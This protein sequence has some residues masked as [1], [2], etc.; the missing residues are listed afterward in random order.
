MFRTVSSGGAAHGSPQKGF[1]GLF[2]DSSAPF[3][4]DRV[5]DGTDGGGSGGSA[6]AAVAAALDG[7]AENLAANGAPLGPD[8]LFNGLAA[9]LANHGAGPET[10]ALLEGLATRLLI[11]SEAP[12]ETAPGGFSPSKWPDPAGF[13]ELWPSPHKLPRD[14]ILALTADLAA[15]TADEAAALGIAASPAFLEAGIGDAAGLRERLSGGDSI[16]VRAFRQA[17]AG[18]ASR[19]L[20]HLA[21][22]WE[23]V[24]ACLGDREAMLRLSS[25]MTG[26]AICDLTLSGR[27]RTHLEQMAQAWSRL[28][29]GF[30]KGSADPLA[31]ASQ[32]IAVEG[33]RLDSLDAAAQEMAITIPASEAAPCQERASAPAGQPSLRPLDAIGDAQSAD[34]QNASRRFGRLLSPLPLLGGRSAD[35]V[36]RSLSAEFP[37]FSDANAEIA[38]SAAVCGRA[39]TG[40]FRL[41]RPLLLVGPPGSGKTRWARRAAVACGVA[42]APV[43]LSGSASSIVL[44]GTERGWSSGTPSL[45]ARVM[46]ERR[47]ANPLIFLDEVDKTAESKQNGSATDA[48]LMLTEPETAARYPDAY[49][50]GL[51]D[52]SRISFVMAANSLAILPPALLDR[53]TVVHVGRPEA[54]HFGILLG[55]IMADLQAEAGMPDGAMPDL[56]DARPALERVFLESRSA[57][58]LKAAAEKAFRAAIW[59]PPGPRAVG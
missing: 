20:E 18:H 35:E 46:Q 54:R 57:R 27:F 53:V 44:A 42:F 4:M 10:G 51:L 14:E 49:L 24:L 12:F 28:A 40:Y 32:I 7:I 56:S 59:T 11:A 50:L 8:A 17:A 55:G 48:L 16:A 22:N 45:P 43:S 41:L 37:W 25:S 21:L 9:H 2:A 34:G 5:P 31:E 23:Y 1:A 36:W 39:G 26:M 15:E 47:T 38:G 58:T 29:A 33:F 6:A 19:N 3:Q 52:L 13:G 30:R